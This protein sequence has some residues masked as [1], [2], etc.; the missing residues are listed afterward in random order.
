MML[1]LH[2]KRKYLKNEHFCV[3]CY[4]LQATVELGGQHSRGNMIIEQ[5]F[6]RTGGQTFEPNVIVVDSM[7]MDKIQMH[8]VEAFQGV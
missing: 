8:L 6:Y 5:R 1:Y 7:D 3:K 4:I 2:F